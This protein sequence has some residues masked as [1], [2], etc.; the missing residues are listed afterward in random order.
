MRVLVEAILDPSLTEV[1]ESLTLTLMHLLNEPRTRELLLQRSLDVTA[2]LS[3]FTDAETPPSQERR[4]RWAASRA[5]IVTMMR[6]WVG[7]VVLTADPHGALVSSCSV[8][9]PDD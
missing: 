1:A 2:L 7:V 5:A 4:L 6:T 8:S 9:H 3:P